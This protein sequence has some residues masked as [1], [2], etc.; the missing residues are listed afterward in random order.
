V[1]RLAEEL[2]NQRA[3]DR[4]GTAVSVLVEELGDPDAVELDGVDAG[5]AVGVGRAAHQ[6]R[7]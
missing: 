5:E 7:T 2:T 3:E 6:P 4:I 1:S